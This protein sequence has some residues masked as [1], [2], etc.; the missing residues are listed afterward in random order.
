MVNAYEA[1]CWKMEDYDL[2]YVKY[3][4]QACESQP[5]DASYDHLIAKLKKACDH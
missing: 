3:F 2:K 4:V 1:S 5:I